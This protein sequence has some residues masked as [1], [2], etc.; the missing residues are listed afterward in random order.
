MRKMKLVAL[1][2]LL[3]MTMGFT[4][5]AE[6][7]SLPNVN[8]GGEVVKV[9][10]GTIFVDKEGNLVDVSNVP[11]ETVVGEPTMFVEDEEVIKEAL[12]VDSLVGVNNYMMDITL[13][14]GG[15]T[16]HPQNGGVYIKIPG[17]PAVEEGAKVVVFHYTGT[18]WERI[19][20]VSVENGCIIAGPFN[21]FSPV[22]VAVAPAAT[23]T[24]DPT[25]T[26]EPT[27][28]PDPAP[29]PNESVQNTSG[30]VV[31]P[32]TGESSMIYVAEAAA[33]IATIG[34]FIYGKKARV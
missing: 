11:V 6:G 18:E 7:E 4:V 17:V 24:P 12:K 3:C 10:E 16:V 14:A 23:T 1:S 13:S 19:A 32:K 20:N 26:P 2:M 9:E 31:S 5:H 8:A 21:S 33:M 15:V 27:P 34:L 25:P 30:N 22:H 29:T 28:T